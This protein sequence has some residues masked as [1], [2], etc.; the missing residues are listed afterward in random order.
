MT[1]PAADAP[2]AAVTRPP[3]PRPRPFFLIVGVAAVAMT[4]WA[5][6]RIQ[7][8]LEPLFVGNPRAWGIVSQ[9]LTPNWAFL[10]RPAV[11]SAWI[12]TLVMAVL[13]TLVGAVAGL[14]FALLASRATNRSSWLLRLVRWFLS[15]LRSL[16]EIGYAYLMVAMVSTGTLAGL[17]ALAVFNTGIIAKLTSETVDA[18]VTGP[19]EAA[20]A[21]GATTFQRSLTA[22]LPQVWPGFLSYVLYVFEMNLRAS[23]IIGLVGAG[24]IGSLINVERARFHYDNVSVMII[25]LV[26][27]VI[28][29]DLVSRAAR[30]RLI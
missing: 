2:R 12:E 20:D 29:L 10:A 6:I 30:R 24:G 5:G 15:V 7:F 13:A 4:V 3:R 11:A 16:P 19:L 25:G 9:Y 8:T 27:I 26:V 23:A 17:L 18:V 22:V 1:A 28:L 21:A 14:V